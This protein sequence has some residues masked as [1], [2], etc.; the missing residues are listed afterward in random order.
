MDWKT[1]WG[2]NFKNDDGLIWSHLAV[3]LYVSS[4][5]NLSVKYKNKYNFT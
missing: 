2:N 5:L 1:K 4:K 3:A